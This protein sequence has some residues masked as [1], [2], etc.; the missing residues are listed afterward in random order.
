MNRYSIKVNDKTITSDTIADGL[1]RVVHKIT[2]NTQ[3]DYRQACSYLRSIDRLERRGISYS[4]E[5]FDILS[6]ARRL[7]ERNGCL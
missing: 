3:K 6:A 2:D 7:V 1:R 5:D 4:N